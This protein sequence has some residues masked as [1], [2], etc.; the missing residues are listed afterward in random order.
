ME[1]N[2][3]A[4]MSNAAELQRRYAAL[5][6]AKAAVDALYARWAELEEKQA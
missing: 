3:P 2:D 4:I 1:A 5:A 6:D